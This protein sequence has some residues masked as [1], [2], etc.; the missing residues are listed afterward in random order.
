MRL[1]CAHIGVGNTANCL[2]LKPPASQRFHCTIGAID[3]YNHDTRRVLLEMPAGEVADFRAGQYLHV[4][5]PSGESP[6][7]I[8]NSPRITDKIEL[9]VRPAPESEGSLL[10]E[11]LLDQAMLKS[12]FRIE[13]EM[14]LGDCYITEVPSS[15]LVLIAASTGITQMKSIIEFLA[16][17]G[18]AQPIH[19]YWGVV[20]AQDL[21]FSQV[22]EAWQA[23]HEN[24]YFT[25]VVSAPESSPGWQGSR[26][27]VGDVALADFEKVS[28]LTVYI[29]GGPAMVY[30]IFDAFIARGLAA[31]RIFSDVFSYSPRD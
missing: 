30:A 6:F 18:F 21:Y 15:P 22:C 11:A 16:P 3:Y 2:M 10:I 14:P 26:G 9:H 7:T 13:I 24:F 5:L 12:N 28:E 1:G 31:D 27:L 4:L 8:A 20:S 23:E 17:S 19:L 25:P 29:S